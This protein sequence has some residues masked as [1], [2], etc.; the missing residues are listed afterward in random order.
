MGGPVILASDAFRSG[1]PL[2]TIVLIAISALV[3]LYQLTLSD[4]DTFKF[5]YQYGLIPKELTSGE[6]LEIVA[7]RT[8]AGVVGLDVASPIPTW[9]TVFT[10]MFMH[11]GWMH[12]IG[13]MLFL[14]GFGEKV[15]AKLGH[16]KYLLFYLGAGIAAAWTQV[17]ADMDSQAV[18]IGA[19]GAIFGVLGAYL[20]AF[21][22]ERA[23]GLLFVF[24]LMPLVFSIGA[25]GPANPG[26]GIAYMAHVGGFVA[27]VAFMAGYK[28]L[29]REPVLP[30]RPWRPWGY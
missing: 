9:G 18:V 2:V 10:S 6:P 30:R 23:I 22:Y 11:G 7:L 20:I 14:W 3:F 25:V 1:R 13:N 8:S 27:G 26:S 21:P 19:S 17:A 5:T 29:L 12:I 15:E 16:I 28:F 4:L 24:F